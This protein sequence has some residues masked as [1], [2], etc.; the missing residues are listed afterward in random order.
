MQAVVYILASTG[1]RVEALPDL[2][3][4]NYQNNRL[5]ICENANQEYFTF[6]TVECKTSLDQYLEMRKRYGEKP[7]PN[8]YL[9]RNQFDIRNPGKANILQ[10]SNS[11]Q[12]LRFM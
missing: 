2:R 10:T 12:H 3:L 5:I 6:M 1:I 11:I 4:R 9:I 8:S 7:T